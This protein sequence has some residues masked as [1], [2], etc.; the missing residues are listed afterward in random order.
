MSANRLTSQ[1]CT[2]GYIERPNRGREKQKKIT[3]NNSTQSKTYANALVNCFMF[4]FCF[5]VRSKCIDQKKN[6]V[7]VCK[8]ERNGNQ[9]WHTCGVVLGLFFLWALFFSGWLW[10]FW[11]H[12]FAGVHWFLID[13]K[14][15]AILALARV[16]L[17]WF[18]QSTENGR[19]SRYGV[20]TTG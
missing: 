13:Q 17:A 8:N 12:W 1:E 11:F 20:E 3:N 15:N 14:T 10:C 19:I 2:A 18:V 7:H 16:Y 5:A 6:S 4:L 9:M